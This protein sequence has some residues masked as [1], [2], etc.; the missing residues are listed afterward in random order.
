MN[1]GGCARR[2]SSGRFGGCRGWQTGLTL[3]SIR[4]EQD[5]R[6]GEPS[7]DGGPAKGRKLPSPVF[8]SSLETT[9]PRAVRGRGRDAARSRDSTRCG[10]RCHRRSAFPTIG[11]NEIAAPRSRRA[12]PLKPPNHP[13]EP[14]LG[15][16][17]NLPANRAIRRRPR[18]DV[19][20][21]THRCDAN[22]GRQRLSSLLRDLTRGMR[23][24]V[25][26]AVL[27]RTESAASFKTGSGPTPTAISPLPSHGSHTAPVYK[28]KK[29]TPFGPTG[30]ASPRLA[31]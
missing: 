23:A 9:D 7:G 2:D 14:L 8:D 20:A 11:A 10:A 25:A 30:G 31:N 16:E 13:P 27:P 1:V 5:I 29:Y 17:I 18:G 15:K 26:C 12:C 24:V 3:G 21:M 6:L 4:G 28:P 22:G 19:W